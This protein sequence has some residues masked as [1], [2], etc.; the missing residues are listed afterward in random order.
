[1]KVKTL[2]THSNGYGEKFEKRRGDEYDHPDAQSLINSKVVK[3]VKD[4]ADSKTGR[5]RGH[6]KAS[7]SASEVDTEKSGDKGDGSES[8]ANE[9][10]SP[11][12]SA[13]RTNAKADGRDRDIKK[14]KTSRAKKK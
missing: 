8:G 3:E 7:V 1:M 2:M 14:D 11:A 9:D 4:N 10:H 12:S 13:D 6:G 5:R